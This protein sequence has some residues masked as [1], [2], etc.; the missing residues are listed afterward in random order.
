LPGGIL[1]RHLFHLRTKKTSLLASTH[2]TAKSLTASKNA[3]KIK[4]EP[5]F[6]AGYIGH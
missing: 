2:A 4:A 5:H 1:A 3:I 6:I